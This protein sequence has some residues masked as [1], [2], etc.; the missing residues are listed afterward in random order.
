MIG[1]GPELMQAVALVS[2]ARQLYDKGEDISHIFVDIA[3][4]VRKCIRENFLKSSWYFAS[5]KTSDPKIITASN[6]VDLVLSYLS[7]EI[8]EKYN[9]N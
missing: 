6:F 5:I 7:H 8:E 1:D 3:P 2:A 4:D 9:V